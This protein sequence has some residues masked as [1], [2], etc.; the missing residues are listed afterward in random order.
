MMKHD[1]I[2]GKRAFR[3]PYVA[4]GLAFIIFVVM[5]FVWLQP[6]IKG[7]ERV[8]RV[9][10][11]S[12]KDAR[13]ILQQA[14]FESEVESICNKPPQ[15]DWLVT[16]QSVAGEWQEPG[17]KVRL[18]V[19]PPYVM[20]PPIFGLTVEEAGKALLTAGFT[21]GEITEQWSDTVPDGCVIDAL[22]QPRQAFAGS[23][24][25]LLVSRGPKEMLMPNLVGLTL[26][27]ARKILAAKGIAPSR[28]MTDISPSMPKDTITR[29]RP[30]A[31]ADMK[32]YHEE[33]I[34]FVNSE[35]PG[36]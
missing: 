7:M 11:E 2:P 8:P 17:T 19:T 5:T 1:D 26:E 13:S 29:T 33:V 22:D 36:N 12:L 6:R 32:Q 34:L 23:T 9:V 21:L 28:T 24:I 16:D 4:A 20:L 3:P 27:D 35:A 10:G 25:N 31:G 30:V 14:N 15:D 18:V